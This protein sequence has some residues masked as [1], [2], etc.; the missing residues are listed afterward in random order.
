MKCQICEEN[1]AEQKHH[2]SYYPDEMTINICIACHKR[3]HNHP[4]GASRKTNIEVIVDGRSG[5]RFPLST[6]EIIST[7]T[8]NHCL[9]D[10][11]VS[12]SLI[13][14]LLFKKSISEPRMKCIV[15]GHT[16]YDFQLDRS[17]VSSSYNGFFITQEP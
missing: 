8:C 15:C 16:A 6:A 9:E 12:Q 13:N 17:Y 5:A 3:L 1:E 14:L 10:I 7:F 11:M 2:V 4:V